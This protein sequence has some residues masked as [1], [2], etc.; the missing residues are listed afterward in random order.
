MGPRRRSTITNEGGQ[1]SWRYH[2]RLRLE[3]RGFPNS[4]ASVLVRAA[5]CSSG[6]YAE[7]FG[8]AE[9]LGDLVSSKSSRTPPPLDHQLAERRRADLRAFSHAE[10]RSGIRPARQKR[11]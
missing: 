10:A 2:N 7:A 8:S 1:H 5:Q 3:T 9:D 11:G 6:M 4:C